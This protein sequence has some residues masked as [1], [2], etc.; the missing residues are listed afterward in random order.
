[1]N[2]IEL[3]EQ[4]V[5]EVDTGDLEAIKASDLFTDSKVAFVNSLKDETGYPFGLSEDQIIRLIYFYGARRLDGNAN[6]LRKKVENFSRGELMALNTMWGWFGMAP[7]DLS[8]RKGA[9]RKLNMNFK[10]ILDFLKRRPA[11][12]TNNIFQALKLAGYGTVTSALVYVVDK[13]GNRRLRL[14]TPTGTREQVPIGKV[15]TMMWD[16]QNV[17]L[18]KIKLIIDSI[19]PEDIKKSNLGMKSKALRDIFSMYHMSRLQNKSQNLSLINVNIHDS[20]AKE[21]LSSLSQYIQKNRQ[22]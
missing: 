14:A 2:D 16:I 6:T 13:E 21:K 19:S 3:L 15:D 10:T 18:D 22:E 20:D 11:F 8:E 12:V 9:Y 4:E 7:A 1:L 5:E 17:S